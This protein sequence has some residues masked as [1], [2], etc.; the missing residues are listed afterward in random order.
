M[1]SPASSG[2]A[3]PIAIL[4]A[5]ACVTSPLG[6]SQLKLFPESEMAQMGAAAYQKMRGEMKESADA[7][8][9]RAARCV[10]DAITA[11]IAGGRS[12]GWEVTVFEDPT[13]NA[14]ALPGGKIGVHTGL[15]GVARN[16]DQLATVIGHEVA[17]VLAGHANER[18]STQF[19]AQAGLSAV[20]VL[21]GASSP[22][23]Q[24]LLGLLGV[25][26]QVGV[27]LPFSRAQ[28]READ[29]LGLDLMAKAGFDPAQSVELWQNMEA[30]GDGQP[31][32]FLST[33]PS[34]GTRIQDLKQ[35][36]PSAQKLREAARQRGK[37]PAC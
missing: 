24:Q 32:E 11:E 34:H 21:A 13:P 1:P 9:R 25:G 19:A 29:L 31:P 17:H 28:E 18:V 23:Q 5:L 27:I 15:F 8:A 3:A 4:L 26:A 20:S 6:R 12:A 35:R 22:A 14:F 30:A 10:A 37:R 2:R 36:I 7:Q 16:Q 33:H